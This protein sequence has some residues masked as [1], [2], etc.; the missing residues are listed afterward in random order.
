[1]RNVA[2]ALSSLIRRGRAYAKDS[3]GIAAVEFAFLAPVALA[4]MSLGVAGGQSLTAYHKV[5]LTA[6]TVT[7]LVSRTV[8]KQDG[9]TSNSELLKQSELDTDLMLSQMVMY[10]QSTDNLIVVM[11]ELKV[12]GGENKGKV[13]WSQSCAGGSGGTMT[14][15]GANKL[16]VGTN[17][18]LD[19]SY[20]L[21]GA[22][23]VLYGQVYYNFQ[24]LGGIFT[25]PAMN[26]TA[27]EV[28]TIRNAGQIT[29]QWG[30]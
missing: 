20:G 17:I 14:C 2:V 15:D 23:Y 6:H 26:L 4:L 25:L 29:V 7:D 9:G 27:T 13:V 21:S 10:P 11:S 19:Q 16:A 12:D 18:P 24:A 22:T 30:S 5:V 28:L 3:T 1:L 8:Y